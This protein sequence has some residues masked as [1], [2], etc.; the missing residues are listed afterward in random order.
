MG[1]TKTVITTIEKTAAAVR[2]TTMIKKEIAAT[3]KTAAT[4]K[5]AAMT[6]IAVAVRILS[7]MAKA[8][9]IFRT[10]AII[11]TR[12]KTATVTTRASKKGGAA[13]FV[14]KEKYI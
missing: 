13:N 9:K 3:M 14:R 11:L 5:I 4:T 8:P 1:E 2:T 7:I 6:E 12:E 10:N